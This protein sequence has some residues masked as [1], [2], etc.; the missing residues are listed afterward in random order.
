VSETTV[1]WGRR[2]RRSIR[3]VSRRENMGLVY[4]SPF[5]IGFLVFSLYPFL[6]SIFYS[7]TDY[8][9]MRAPRFVGARNYVAMFTTDMDFTKSLL[10]TLIYSFAGVPLRLAFA[11]GIALLLNMKLRAVSVFRTIY[12]IP[13]MLG[14]SVAVAIVWRSLFVSDGIIN[15]AI[16]WLGLGPVKW[17]GSPALALGTI[18][19][20]NVW[21]FGSSMLIFLAGLKQ[22]PQELYNVA[23][24]DGAGRVRVFLKITMPLI[25]P[26]IFFN[27]IMQMINAL[28]EFSAPFLITRGL[29]DPL[30]F[31]YFFGMMLYDNAF[32]YTKM[33]YACAL[34]WVQFAII[35]ALTAL[36]FRSSK[37]WVYYEDGGK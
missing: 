17:L 35:L 30:K 7:F 10:I 22:I 27:L 5:L 20:L 2:G 3:A 9:M 4:V 28:Q 21:Q 8:N 19:L 18:I 37:T 13:S 24:V 36:I 12:Y 26:V 11:L 23:A 16:G 15:T 14:G 33:G 34:S 29:G 1:K 25:T 31:T 6:A 32:R